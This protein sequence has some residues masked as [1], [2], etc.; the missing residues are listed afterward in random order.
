MNHEHDPITERLARALGW[1]SLGLGLAQLTA[2]GVL[3]RATGLD[4]SATARTVLP[5]VGVRVTIND[6]A[7]H[8][9]DS[10]ELSFRTASIMGFR[11]AHENA[12][13]VVL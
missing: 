11:E 13:P 7:S 9:V 10:D 4:G 6:G 3:A 1:T 5:I 2:P 8:D 12:G